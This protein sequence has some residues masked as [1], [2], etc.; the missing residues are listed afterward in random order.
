MTLDTSKDKSREGPTFQKFVVWPT[1]LLL[2]QNNFA[3][4]K[5]QRFAQV[6]ITAINEAL[7]TDFQ[8]FILDVDECI[9]EH[10]GPIL[11][12]NLVHAVAM[13]ESGLRGCISS[14]MKA[15]DRYQP[16]IDA[17]SGQVE[18]VMSPYAKPDPRNTVESCDA[19]G[20]PPEKVV[21][22]G[23]NPMTD[24]GAVQAGVSFIRIDPVETYGESEFERLKRFPQKAFRG[25]GRVLS[26]VTDRVTGRDVYR[27]EDSM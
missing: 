23:D 15:S 19:L 27:G 5:F 18:V 3:I 2:P 25:Y 14:N 26:D 17:T 1:K 16:L 12:E 22:I 4:A 8:G 11:P 6:N 13:V 24:G 21:M 10:H 9:A 20:L 7:G